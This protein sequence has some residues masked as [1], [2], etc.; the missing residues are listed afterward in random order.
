MGEPSVSHHAHCILL[1]CL[2][3][4]FTVRCR[5]ELVDEAD[6]CFILSGAFTISGPQN[7]EW[8]VS[9]AQATTEGIMNESRALDKTHPAVKHVLYLR[10]LDSNDQ[11]WLFDGGPPVLIDPPKSEESVRLSST[12]SWVAVGAAVTVLATLVMLLWRRRQRRRGAYDDHRQSGCCTRRRAS[13]RIT[14]GY[15]AY[16]SPDRSPDQRLPPGPRQS[17]WL[18]DSPAVASD[19]SQDFLASPPLSWGEM[20]EE[21]V[22]SFD[23]VFGPPMESQPLPMPANG[24]NDDDP[25]A[26]RS[27]NNNSDHY[28]NVDY[29][30]RDVE[31]HDGS[32][33]KFEDIA[34]PT[35]SVVDDLEFG[36]VS[37]YDDDMDD[38]ESYHKWRTAQETLPDRAWLRDLV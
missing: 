22:S 2:L 1:A 26:S 19:G 6:R 20:N 32:F 34:S 28:N 33:P 16:P 10:S 11:P 27:N 23:P 8:A 5:T 3:P 18:S 4:L 36:A 13:N 31:W 24:C 21:P 37:F 29:Q 9:A 14:R 25:P 38:D 17:V 7:V 35:E 12:W 15:M 30:P